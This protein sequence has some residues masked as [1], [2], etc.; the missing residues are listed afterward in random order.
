MNYADTV[1]GF[2]RFMEKVASD[3]L[4]HITDFTSQKERFI[5]AQQQVAKS[6]DDFF[7]VSNL[8]DEIFGDTVTDFTPV[9][10]AS[11]KIVTGLINGRPSYYQI[12]DDAFYNSVAELSLQQTSGILWIMNS[13]MQSM[14]ILAT[15]N[16]P[17]FAATNALRD[18]G[19]AYKLSEI[20][21]PVTFATQYVK[22]LGGMLSNS[23]SYQKYKAMG[24]GHSS[25][26]SANIGNIASMLRKVAQKD[27]GKARRLA[28]SIFRHPVETVASI[29]DA[30]ESISRFME[31]Q[32][33]LDT[34]GDLQQ[35]IF[36]ADDITT[37]FKRSGRGAT[38][39]V[40]NKTIMFNNAAI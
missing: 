18:F 5:D 28:Y 20:N 12:H 17:I 36:N 31:F 11:K 8:F 14:K 4:K 38:V 27:A 39:K 24:G 23:E 35:A 34:G 10:N 2:G 26:L 15:Q 25:E 19:T 30:V 9:A 21:N 7:V 32:R 33:T 40:L 6:S 1:K 29:N 13:I 37:N 16:N 3:I 22:A